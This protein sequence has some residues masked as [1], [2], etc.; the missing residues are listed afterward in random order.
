MNAFPLAIALPG[1]AQADHVA[2]TSDPPRYTIAGVLV[3]LDVAIPDDLLAAE[4]VRKATKTK[5]PKH[6]APAPR[7]VQMEL[8]R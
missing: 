4:R 7:A 3:D 1:G 2:G 8:F 6:D 5:R